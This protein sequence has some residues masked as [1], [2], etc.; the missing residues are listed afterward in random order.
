M[1]LPLRPVVVQFH[2]AAGM[3]HDG[4]RGT[5]WAWAWDGWDVPGAERLARAALRTWRA[6]GR[7]VTCEIEGRIVS[8]T[9]VTA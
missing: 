5:S 2:D 7:N 6:E 8:E 3:D 4:G 1:T 9:E